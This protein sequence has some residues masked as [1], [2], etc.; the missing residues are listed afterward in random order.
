MTF[1]D[2]LTFSNLGLAYGVDS[3]NRTSGA[4]YTEYFYLEIHVRLEKEGK[5]SWNRLD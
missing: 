4:M 5:V 3:I 2:L 1:P